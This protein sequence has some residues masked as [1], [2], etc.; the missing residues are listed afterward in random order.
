VIA[1]IVFLVLDLH[2]Q[3]SLAIGS[4]AIAVG[5]IVVTCIY[6]VRRLLR[7]DRLSQQDRE[8]QEL[9][10]DTAVNSMHQGLVMFDEDRRAVI[11]NRPYIEMYRLSPEK[12]KP[13]C[14][15]RELLE[16][17]AALGMFAGNIDE[18][19]ARQAARGHYGTRARDLPDGRTISVTNRPL[20]NG[21]WVAVHEDITERRK[22]E[23]AARRLFETSLDL[24]LITDRQGNVA[25]VSPSSAAILGYQPEEMLGCNA[26]TFVFPDDLEATRNEMRSA[27]RGLHTR[28]FETRYLHKDGR[29]VTLAWTGVWSE[30]EQQHFFIGRDITE[31]KQVEQQLRYLAHYD[32]LTGLPNRITLQSELESIIEGLDGNS[33]GPTSIAM[34][35]LDGFKNIN[36]TL[37]HSI[38]DQLL[39]VVARRLR[40]VAESDA[41]VYRLGGDEFVVVFAQCGDPRVI[42]K[43]V[44]AMLERLAERIEIGNHLLYIGASVG[45][46]IAPTDASNV[47]ELVAN[48]DL[49][50]YDA[51]A[52]GGRTYRLFLPVLRAQAQARRELD[53]ELR[54]AFS[55]NEFELYFQP[56]VR[57]RNGAIVGAEALLRWR[58]PERGIIG[59][60]MFI[61]AIAESPIVLEVGRWILHTACARAAAWRESGF[62]QLRVGVNLFPAQFKDG[63]L[64]GDV[65]DALRK[66]G[67][68]P[69]AL[70][71]EI[72]ENIA[73]GSD[74]AVL[75]Q[76]QALREKGIHFAFDD[77]GT[78]FASLSYLTRYPISRIKIDQTFVRKISAASENTAIV[79]SIIV[80]AHN[81]GLEVIAEG[82]ETAAHAAFLQAEGCDEAQGFLY[83]KA[84]RCD[85]F[86]KFM[87]SNQVASATHPM[88]SVVRLEQAFAQRQAG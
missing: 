23:R 54:R 8:D 56:Q 42:G 85:E 64:L 80:M 88:G 75:E 5:I 62:A 74:E 18:Y 2:D 60:G 67:L 6:M 30:A 27:R 69:E 57:L 25:Q 77:F 46:A 24:I 22:A 4:G 48:A 44:D 33:F 84:L 45:I 26:G 72:T 10:L 83:A 1:A 39:K 14:T 34:F 36:D 52:S 20:P 66:T 87:R 86:E 17:R 15:L 12:A 70:E 59:P 61:E 71:L 50:L 43:V 65:E 81:L 35:D 3:E 47:E 49:A 76:L 40:E 55:D 58:H 31:R 7:G 29:V 82:V 16:M 13:G 28:S 41:R 9:K 78:G 51:K 63:T 73:L 32:Q 21:G 19:I 38:G 79:R 53:T 37:G 11:I 68:P